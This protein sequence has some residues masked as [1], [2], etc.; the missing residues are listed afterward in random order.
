MSNSVPITENL[1]FPQSFLRIG[2]D[3]TIWALD[4]TSLA[5]SPKLLA[6][7]P[8]ALSVVKPVAGTLLLA[9][10]LAG[11]IVLTPVPPAGGW[12][13]CAKLASP[14]LYLPSPAGIATNS[15]GYMLAGADTDLKAVQEA[16]TA[17][18]SGSTR[19]TV[20]VTLDGTGS[21][22]VIN[23][24]QLPFVVLATAVST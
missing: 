15:P 19:L 13:P 6:D 16:I 7:G 5:V 17:A 14:Y 22:V 23:G 3:P 20:N 1:P 18:M 10:R 21:I 8:A 9:P 4:E 12:V 11:S 24:A 2:G